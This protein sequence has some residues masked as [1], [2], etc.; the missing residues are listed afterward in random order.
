MNN[1]K[2][3]SSNVYGQGLPYWLGLD[4][5]LPELVPRFIPD[6]YRDQEKGL[7][8]AGISRNRDPGRFL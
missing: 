7:G 3:Q 6:R 8:L 1:R 5:V 4:R 2:N